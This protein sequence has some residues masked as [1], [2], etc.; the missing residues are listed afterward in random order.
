M[1]S[2]LERTKKIYLRRVENRNPK[3]TSYNLKNSVFISESFLD[4]MGT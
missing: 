3:P 2:F 1:Y 4:F